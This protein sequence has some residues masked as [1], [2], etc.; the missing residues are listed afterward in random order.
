MLEGFWMK[1][2]LKS[3]NFANFTSKEAKIKRKARL[4][5]KQASELSLN[6]ASQN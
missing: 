1:N 6:G 2:G 4:L 5:N 3:L